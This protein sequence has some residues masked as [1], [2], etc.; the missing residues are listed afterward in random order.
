MNHKLFNDYRFEYA[1]SKDLLCMP[2]ATDK[3]KVV[4]TLIELCDGIA[5]VITIA[6][7]N[8]SVLDIMNITNWALVKQECEAL[9]RIHFDTKANVIVPANVQCPHYNFPTE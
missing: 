1:V 2:V 6:F 3:I 9:A 4:A 8:I 7:E 5:P